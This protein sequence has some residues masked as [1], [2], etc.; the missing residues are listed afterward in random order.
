MSVKIT[1]EGGEPLRR[2]DSGPRR[3]WRKIVRLV[4]RKGAS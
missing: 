1:S 4:T 2:K 3:L